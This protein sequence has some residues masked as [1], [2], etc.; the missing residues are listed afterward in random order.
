MLNAVVTCGSFANAAQLLHVTQPAVSY[1]IARLEEQLGMRLLKLEGRKA[2]LTGPGETLLKRAKVLLH[3]AI[4]LEELAE[5]IRKGR[6]PEVKLAVDKTFPVSVLVPALRAFSSHE[7]N[8]WV[9]LAELSV[10]K[11][12]KVLREGTVDLAINKEV[13]DGFHGQQLAEI[14]YVAVA[15]PE[16]QLFKFNR[17]VTKSDLEKELHII[18]NPD[19]NCDGPKQ[20]KSDSIGQ[21]W[22]V[23]NFDTAERVL[24][25]CLGYGW[26]PRQCVQASLDNRKLRMLQLGNGSVFKTS[27]YLVYARSSYRHSQVSRLAEALHDAAATTMIASRIATPTKHC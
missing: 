15:H 27:Y 24:T 8:A 25:Q 21:C 16:H 12:Q 1:T 10:L 19:A 14:E 4:E 6:G 22:H 5:R 20:A 2:Q 18:V 7:G 23:S 13:P 3:D 9:H 11:V 17:E 26:L